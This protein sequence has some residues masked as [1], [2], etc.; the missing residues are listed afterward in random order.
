MP[1]HPLLN[2][3]DSPAASG[4][5]HAASNQ[6]AVAVRARKWL[7]WITLVVCAGLLLYRLDHYALWDDEAG[8]ALTAKSILR[9]GDATA[10]VDD[11]NVFAYRAGFE[12]RGMKLRYLPPLPAHIVATSFLISGHPTER[13]AR[14]P[15]A[16]FGLACIATVLFWCLRAAVPP[17]TMALVALGLLTNVSLL[18]YSRQCRYYALAILLSTLL[19]F[20]YFRWRGGRH[21]L[22]MIAVLLVLLFATNYLN[23]AALVVCLIVDYVVWRRH[24]Q[25]L[26]PADWILLVLP[27]ILFC[28]VIA[29]V[30]NP[31]G[32][33]AGVIRATLLEKVTLLGWQFRDMNRCE[34]L[35][36]AV[37][38]VAAVLAFLRRDRWLIRALAALVLYVVTV[39]AFSPQPVSST[40]A[41]DVR[42]LVPVIP[43]GIFIS[44]RTLLALTRE[45]AWLVLPLAAVVF[46]TNLLHGGPL[47]WSGARSTIWELVREISDPPSDPYRIASDWVKAAVPAGR[48]V[49]VL[50]DAMAYPL[51]FHA[52]HAIYAWQLPAP[53]SGQFTGLPRIHFRGLQAPDYVLVFG[54]AVQ[55]V[56][57]LL[58]EWGRLGVN[59]ELVTRL[60]HYWSD[61][62]RPELIWRR[63]DRVTNFDPHTEAI[64]VFGR[65][66][67]AARPPSD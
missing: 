50:P 4:L 27:Q 30:W 33:P 43:L 19:A 60:D 12:L 42:Y 15:F 48:S 20:L 1:Q 3:D 36:G 32:S 8:T 49:W 2:R 53:P 47:L 9:N 34:F 63:F 37:L 46:G 38:V 16:L 44:V 61:Q 18:L 55:Q 67:T 7:A 51:M 58:A 21:R 11:H 23:Y 41:A 5:A 26:R 40:F 64:Y 65:R 62:H 24:E 29:W 17:L 28:G 57:P 25:P 66:P 22:A 52:P 56:G 54:P 10:F 39:T 45:K 35:C 59:L 6:P 13:A 14:L 31:S